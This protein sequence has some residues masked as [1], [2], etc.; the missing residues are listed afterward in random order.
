MNR[1]GFERSPRGLI[2]PIVVYI[3]SGMGTLLIYVGGEGVSTKEIAKLL[4][5]HRLN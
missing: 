2:V 3:I 5:Y 1:K 4:P